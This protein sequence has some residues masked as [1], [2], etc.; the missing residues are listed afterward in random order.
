MSLNIKN[1]RNLLTKTKISKISSILSKRFY[2]SNGES[3]YP[4][5]STSTGTAKS[6]NKITIPRQKTLHDIYKMYNKKEPISV[7][8]AHDYITGKFA[9][10]SDKIDIVLIGDSL[11]MVTMG[12]PNTLEM[13]FEEFYYSSKY[14]LR[15]IDSKFIIIDLPFGYFENNLSKCIE[16]SLKL[17][18]LGKIN[19]IKLEGSFEY[20]DE[21]KRLIDIGIPVTG[22]IGLKPQRF[23]SLG[24]FKV[25]GKDSY[26]A[27]KIY[28][29]ALFLQELGISLLV[30]ECVPDKIAKY[31]T[32]KLN[33]PTIGIG[34]GNGTSGQVLVQGDLLGMMNGKNAKFVKRYSDFYELGLNSINKYGEEVKF[35]KFPI[36]GE[37]SYPIKDEEFEN[38]IKLADKL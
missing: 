18:K 4:T 9:N 11:S 34:A 7:I 32:N 12:Y 26:S 8:T 24:G 31:I 33:I 13:T 28:E 5:S 25:Q 35:G 37:Q 6:T 19:S 29:E 16:T 14:I 2:S 38:F 10:D 22:H 21:I 23:N 20:K 17:M 3:P 36:N 30:L 15:G 1:S 27:L